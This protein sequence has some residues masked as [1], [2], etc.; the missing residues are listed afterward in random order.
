M[1][2]DIAEVMRE[3][4]LRNWITTRD[5]N[6]SMRLK[7][8]DNLYITPSA[9][10][11]YEIK[12]SEIVKIHIFEEK[13]LFDASASGELQMHWLLHKNSGK[14]RSVLH[15]H[16]T[17]TVAAMYAGYNLSELSLQFPEIHRYTKVANNVP[18]VPAVSEELAKKTY[19]ALII[20]GQPAYD[21]VGQ[22]RHGVCAIGKDPWEAFEHIER[23][24]HIC[25]MVLLATR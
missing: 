14:T 19:T 17:F 18:V 8:D 20:D 11:K 15:L 25:K 5:G 16:P 3:A 6:C 22:D 13:I 1:L 2:A 4:Y 9:V 7:D 24:E 23:L 10:K 12:P 21:I